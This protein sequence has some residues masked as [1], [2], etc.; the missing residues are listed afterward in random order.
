ME[1][2]K[3]KLRGRL[4]EQ[5]APVVLKHIYQPRLEA[6]VATLPYLTEVNLAH[7]IMLGKKGII[8][9]H[10]TIALLRVLMKID[11]KGIQLFEL[12]AALE[13]LYYNYERYIIEELG[14]NV[15]GR[16]HTGRSRNDLGA[17]LGRMRVRDLVLDI[18]GRLLAFRQT[19]LDVAEQHLETVMIGHTHLQPAQPITLGHYLTAIE[20]ALQRDTARLCLAF[21]SANKSCLGAGALAG[22]GFPID[23][24]LTADLLGFDGFVE[25]TLD[26]VASRD[27]LLELFSNMAILATTLSR[28]AQDMY[29]W[30]TSEFG[31]IDFPDRLGG[32]S[33]IMPQKKNPIVLESC[34]GRLSH[35]FGGLV[36]A[37]SAMKNTNYTNVS[38]VSRESFHLLDDSS[39]QVQAVLELLTALVES[40]EVRKERAYVMVSTGFTT[41]TQLA[42]ALVG[43]KGYSFREAHHIVA[44]V[45]RKA[46]EEGIRATQITSNFIDEVAIDEIGGPIGLTEDSVRNAL[47]PMDNITVRSHEGG[48]APSA[49]ARTIRKASRLIE[50][51]MHYVETTRRKLQS[52]RTSLRKTVREML[53]H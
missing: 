18:L 49:V 52:A 20:Q 21:D 51:D 48:T 32:T 15:G 16:L 37:L 2:G 28:L 24:Q 47:D 3:T 40:I 7:V 1:S 19:L 26:A 29:I 35:V 38:D 6:E 5:P 42:D 30:Y 34:K 31:I 11:E 10:D 46:I 27:Y 4:A 43:E 13:G 9:K 8:S 17:T 33:S 12:D 23:R 45:V 36:S 39:Y 14:S 53:D 25:N 50:K 22:T 41:A 44:S